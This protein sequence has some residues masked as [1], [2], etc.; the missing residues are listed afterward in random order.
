MRVCVISFKTCWQNE[1]GQW[2]SY[3]GFPLQMEAIAS[4]FD[5]MTLIIGSGEP[6][7]GGMPLP[8]GAVVVPLRLP[9]SSDLP[10]KIGVMARSPYYVARMVRHVWSA[11]VVH[12]PLPGDIPLLGLA[13]GLVLRKRTLVRYGSSWQVTAQTTTMNRM[14]KACMRRFAGGRNV[15][16]ATGAGQS[17]PTPGV[18]WIFSTALSNNDVARVQPV[19]TRGLS[20]VPRLVYAGRLSPEKGV[21]IL[22][23]ALARLKAEGMQPLP[24]LTVVGDGPQRAEL[25]GLV[26]RLGCHERV[27]FVGQVDR[28]GLGDHLGR[29]DVCVQPSLTEGFSKAW[30]DAMLYGLPV[31]SSEVGAARW[32]IGS[33]GERGW[34][35]SPGDVDAL[36]CAL[37]G[38]LQKPRD[39]PALRQRCREYV[40]GR[41]LEKWAQTIGHVCSRQWN[42]SL[43]EGKIRA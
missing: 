43:V 26:D 15:M 30:L 7:P 38:V 19:L 6:R 25:A 22:I 36:T 9:R 34:L 35:V 24:V 3:G 33:D 42:M 8:R 23:R 17:T 18:E 41:T 10:R 37:R 16:L 29:A 11:D 20:P 40:E 27:T 28:V 4:L 12:L 1:S 5:R 31:L 32:V 2:C 39:W 14:T 13:L 21:A